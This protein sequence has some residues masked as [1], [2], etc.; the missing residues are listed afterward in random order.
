MEGREVGRSHRS[1]QPVGTPGAGRHVLGRDDGPFGGSGASRS[2]VIEPETDVGLQGIETDDGLRLGNGNIAGA[3]QMQVR[4]LPFSRDK[5]GTRGLELGSLAQSQVG[6][7][8]ADAV[9]SLHRQPLLAKDARQLTQRGVESDLLGR[10]GL[11]S[12]GDRGQEP[13]PVLAEQAPLC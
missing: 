2:V 6:A 13:E 1:R 4:L 9:P 12:V 7:K 10:A 5:C 3:N 8:L 11:R